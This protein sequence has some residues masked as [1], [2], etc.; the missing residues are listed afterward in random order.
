MTISV[1]C[2]EKKLHT[3]DFI[4]KDTTQKCKK[5]WNYYKTLPMQIHVLVHTV[6]LGTKY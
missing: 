5:F 2:M 6:H 4:Y 1:K 3:I